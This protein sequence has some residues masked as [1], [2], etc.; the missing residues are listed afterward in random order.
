MVSAIGI[1]TCD[2]PYVSIYVEREDLERAAR[3]ACAVATLRTS[4]RNSTSADPLCTRRSK[5]SGPHIGAKRDAATQTVLVSDHRVYWIA[6]RK[7]KIP[8]LNPPLEARVGYSTIPGRD[9]SALSG[10]DR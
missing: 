9:S 3:P 2:A 8:R 6:K 5:S 4:G 10:F 7:T 1:A